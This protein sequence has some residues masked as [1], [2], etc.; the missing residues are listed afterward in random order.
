[1]Y[2]IFQSFP[3][4]TICGKTNEQI[5]LY[6]TGTKNQKDE[7]RG[8][9]FSDDALLSG[10]ELTNQY[11]SLHRFKNR[12]LAQFAVENDGIGLITETELKKLFNHITYVQSKPPLMK[13]TIWKK[14]GKFVHKR[15]VYSVRLTAGVAFTKFVSAF[16]AVITGAAVITSSLVGFFLQQGSI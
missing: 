6:S 11:L 2:Q 1:M 15:A 10:V 12:T 16:Y 9:E 5:Y 3:L 13:N 4:K 8:L 14:A 7:L